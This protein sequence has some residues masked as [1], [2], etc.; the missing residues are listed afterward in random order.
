MIGRTLA[1]YKVLEEISRGGM[2]IVYKALDLKLNREVAL[3]LLRSDLV[4]NDER[5]RRFVQEAQAAAAIKHPNIAVVYDIDEAD[6]ETFIAMELIEGDKLGDYMRRDQFTPEKA[7]EIAV[8][9]AAGLA[10]AHKLGIVH[11]DLKPPNIMVTDEGHPKIIDFGLAKL[12]EPPDSPESEAHTVAKE[13][14]HPGELLG[15]FDYMSP[16]QTRGDRID[17]RSDVFSF[18]VVLYEMLACKPLFRR[19][20]PADTMSAILRDDAPPLSV[21]SWPAEQ[22]QKLQGLLDRCLAKQ[23]AERFDSAQELFTALSDVS[24]GQEPSLWSR[25]REPRLALP[26]IFGL[27]LVVVAAAVGV[28]R[29]IAARQA[30]FET[31]PE[32]MRLVEADDYTSAYALAESVESH[33]GDDPILRDLW[34]RFA[35]RTTIE[36]EPSNP[37]TKHPNIGVKRRSASMRATV[38]NVSSPTCSF[39]RA[40]IRPIKS[41]PT[42]HTAGPSA[43]GRVMSCRWNSSTSSS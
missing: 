24:A 15:T 6:G 19:A 40:S 16:E 9:I 5:K 8:G 42:I 20:S 11:R 18:G 33:L 7:L 13:G 25:L 12:V 21:S 3:K 14:T 35:V 30:R 43:N 39:P 28:R 36:T 37:L 32:I 26:L 23:P 10:A 2:G 1:H 22:N 34:S 4:S 38:T 29:S 41:S 31:I 27:L 17:P